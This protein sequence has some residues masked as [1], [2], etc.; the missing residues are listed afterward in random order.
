MSVRVFQYAKCST[1]RKA[2]KWLE[3]KGVAYEAIAIVENPPSAATL[4][5]LHKRSGKPIAKF[6]N[7]S[8]ESYRNGNFKEKLAKMSEAECFAALAKDGKLIKRPLLDAGTAVL[9]GF[10]EAEYK[11][12]FSSKK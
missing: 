2:L 4:R 12:T 7:T 11:A 1:C 5:E 6:F 3:A 10:D 9:V 8:G